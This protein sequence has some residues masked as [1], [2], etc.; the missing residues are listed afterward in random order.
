[1]IA[2]I[3]VAAKLFKLLNF[4]IAKLP[5][6]IQLASHMKRITKTVAAHARHKMANHIIKCHCSEAAAKASKTAFFVF[7]TLHSLKLCNMQHL[8]AAAGNFPRITFKIILHLSE[9]A[10][11][12]I[13]ILLNLHKK[14]LHLTFDALRVWT[15]WRG[16]VGGGC[17]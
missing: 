7:N 12:H 15:G 17:S 16:L 5:A 9:F 11:S 14:Y 2:I 13:S 8:A 1:M 4:I 6:T 10:S 3:R